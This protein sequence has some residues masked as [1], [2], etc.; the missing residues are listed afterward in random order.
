MNCNNVGLLQAWRLTAFGIYGF[1]NFTKSGFQYVFID[2]FL[3]WKCLIMFDVISLC[4]MM[5]NK[6]YVSF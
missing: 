5:I 4:W 2:L 3:H 6:K 1:M